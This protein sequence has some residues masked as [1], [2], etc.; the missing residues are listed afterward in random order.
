MSHYAGWRHTYRPIK[1]GLNAQDISSSVNSNAVGL[2]GMNQVGIEYEYTRGAGTTVTFFV[3]F[4]RRGET[5][6]KRM[7]VESEGVSGTAMLYDKQYDINAESANAQ[8]LI[9]FP[10]MLDGDMRLE[11]VVATGAPTSS[12]TFTVAIHVGVV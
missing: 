4:R 10:V 9:T 5:T 11:S 6:W 12:D 7:K 3:S 8:G 2:D 1:V